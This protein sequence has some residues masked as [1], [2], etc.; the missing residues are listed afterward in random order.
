MNTI[1]PNPVD[2][3]RRAADPSASVWVGASAGTGKTKVLTDRVLSLMLAGTLPQRILCLTFTKTAAAEMSTRI[4]KQLGDWARMDDEALAESLTELVGTAPDAAT[5]TRARRLFAQVLDTPGGINIQTIHAFCQS[6]LGRFPL[7]AGIAPHF[8][9]MDERDAEEM[10]DAAMEE[11]LANAGQ[12][13]KEQIATALAVITRHVRED[14]FVELMKMLSRARGRVR[15]LIERFGSLDATVGHTWKTLGLQIGETPERIN[16]VAS[17]DDSFDQIGLR[18]AAEALSEGSKTDQERGAIIANWLTAAGD[19]RLKMFGSYADTFLANKQTSIRKTLIT[20]GALKNSPGIDEVLA[21]EAER[22]LDVL[23]RCCAAVTAEATSALLYLGDS[24]LES[25]ARHKNAHALLDYD[26]L[27]FGARDLLQKEGIAPWVLFKLDGGLDHIL[28]DEAQDTNPEQWEVVKALA[29]EFFAGSG[30]QESVRTV[31]A[32]GDTKQSIYSFQGADPEAFGTTRDYFAS[33]VSEAQ[34]T[35]RQVDLNISFRSTTVILKAVDF[36]FGQPGVSNRVSLDGLEIQHNAWRKTDG[37]RIE[38]W[39]PVEPLESDAPAPWKPPVERVQGD[40]PEARLAALV[41]EII[42]SMINTGDIL[43]SKGRPVRPGDIMVLVRRRRGFVDALVRELKRRDVAVAGVDRM[44][45][46]EQLAVMD[47]VALG[48]FLLLPD[49]DMTLATVLKS[50]LIGLTEEQLFDLAFD[51]K[52]TL[53]RELFK[54]QREDPAFFD[55]YTYLRDLLS[56]TDFEAPFEL[57]NHILGTLGGRV[58]L[59]ERLGQDADDPINE[60]LDQAL[61]FEKTHVASLQG[62]LHWL[63]AGGIEVKRDLDQSSQDAVRVMTVHGAKGLQAP[64]VF[65]PDTMQ[66]PTQIDALLWPEANGETLMLWPPKREWYEDI[67]EA[68]LEELKRRQDQEYRRLLYVAMTRAEDRLYVCGWHGTRKPSEDCWYNLVER[69]LKNMAET[70]SA[71][72][73][74]HRAEPESDVLSLVCPQTG[75]VKESEAPATAPDISDTV[76]GWMTS[77]PPVEAI[78]PKPLAPSRPDGE[79]PPVQSPFG[80]DDGHRF[81]R[82]RIIHRLLQTL[83]DLAPDA[84]E[85][86]ARSFLAQDVHDLSTEEQNKIAS[87]TM[88]VLNHTEF[89]FLFGPGSQAEVPMVGEIDGQVMSAQLDRL[90]VTD[91]TVYVIDYKTNRPPPKKIE[92]IAVIYLKQMAAYRLALQRIYPEHSVRC[93]LLWSD[94]PDLMELPNTLLTENL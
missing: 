56:Q 65:L 2:A 75:D 68:E 30:A 20:K 62:F 28:V 54:R 44:V 45:L 61:A 92:D 42:Q 33:K 79:A 74:V 3:Q 63:D 23:R 21:N 94:G 58:K 39:P 22:L 67:A 83:P 4:A 66:A 60:F 48:R 76:G 40:S 53:W 78:P 17:D 18:L 26:D 57:F 91:D 87:E 9:V 90:L 36:V 85:G 81:K 59:L 27:I 24:L 6:L 8:S 64:I 93:L 46:T 38:L 35:W 1:T 88:V 34:G 5:L 77:P 51:R 86:A 32:V 25:Y 55:A 31:F 52:N 50:P 47:L 70:P 41:A 89:S 13:S 37:G 49:D 84:R 43:E 10:L 73:A 29:D 14:R 15:H 7:E 72:Y 80:E 82:G 12:H 11:L 16:A 19:V 71:D 69:G